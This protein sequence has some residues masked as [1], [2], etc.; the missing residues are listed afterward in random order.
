MYVSML[1]YDTA[2]FHLVTV[3][4]SVGNDVNYFNF[5]SGELNRANSILTPPFIHNRHGISQ[6][7]SP[8]IC[9]PFSGG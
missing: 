3:A 1:E 9:F 7:I 6:R 5:E 2:W 8:P 4:F